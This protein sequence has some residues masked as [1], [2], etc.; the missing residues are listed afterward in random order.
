MKFYITGGGDRSVGIWP[1]E[2]VVT[3]EGNIQF[4]KDTIEQVRQ[5]LKEFDDN[6]ASVLTEDEYDLMMKA[7]EEAFKEMAT[8]E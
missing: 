3:F 6:G 2:E 7:E 1:T 8:D 4:D 5:M